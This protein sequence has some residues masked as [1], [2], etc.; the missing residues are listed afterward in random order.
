[1]FR[2]FAIVPAAGRSE[3]MGSPK[4]LLPLGDR[5]VIDHVLGAWT[6]SAV[7]RTVVV[8]RADDAALVERCRRFSVDLV[9]PTEPP[10]DMKASVQLGVAHIAANYEPTDADAWLV[11]PADLPGLS[12]RVIDVVLR[13]YDSHEPCVI[14]PV[15]DGERGHPTLL[16]WGLTR[17]LHQ[18]DAEQ[19]INALVAR[20]RLREVPCEL[21]GILDDLDS[22]GDYSR[23][24]QQWTPARDGETAAARPVF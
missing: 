7:T 12:A 9:T 14:A 22:P 3:R 20:T 19:G 16:P 6:A 10:L 17:A 18:L 1:M 23:L 24:T 13:A 8:V 4:L 21:R 5:P 15:H 11:A 2:R